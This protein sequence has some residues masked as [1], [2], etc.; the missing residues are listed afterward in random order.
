[1][2]N[3]N[4]SIVLFVL[5]IAIA[6]AVLVQSL[7]LIV[8]VADRGIEAETTGRALMAE[9]EKAFAAVRQ[10]LLLAWGPRELSSIL[11]SP[12][13]A[14][15]WTTVAPLPGGQ[16][17]ALVVTGMHPESVTPIRLSAWVERGWDGIDLPLAG[18]V[19]GNA[20]WTLGRSTPLLE[21]DEDVGSSTTAAGVRPAC[22]FRT[23]PS[24]PLLGP[25]VAIATLD[26][27]WGLDDG[28][29]KFFEAV[30][31]E[32]AASQGMAPTLPVVIHSDQGGTR[33]LPTGWGTVADAP[34]LMMVT[35]G[36]SLDATGKGD[37][38]GVMVVDGGSVSLDGTRLHGALFATNVVDFGTTGAVIFAPAIL[39]W[40][41]DRA[42]VRARLV[43]GSRS[44][45]VE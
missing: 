45:S 10:E 24:A 30:A 37:I 17:W 25:G 7:A 1:M 35:G 11:T 28:W 36:A 41:T 29:R 6:I 39:R 8:T 16:E 15:V 12:G 18:V 23:P 9:K 34:G 19:G 26:A 32:P 44:E 43:P 3:Q 20:V 4:G 21:T 38:Y 31:E 22:W 14:E 13:S 33:T 42:L 5:F 40:A 2:R 27:P